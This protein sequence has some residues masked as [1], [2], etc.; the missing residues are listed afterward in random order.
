MQLKFIFATGISSL[1]FTFTDLLLFDRLGFCLSVNRRCGAL[2]RISVVVSD[3][4]IIVE[5]GP[6]LSIMYLVYLSD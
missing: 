3:S 2:D 1:V 4:C 6:P 5:S